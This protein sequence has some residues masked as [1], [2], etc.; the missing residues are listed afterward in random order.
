ML[1][2]TFFDRL[3]SGMISFVIGLVLIVFAII[4]WWASTVPERHEFLVPMEMI[5]I[6]GGAE[7]GAPDETLLIE[8]PEDP[9]DD[10]VEEEITDIVDNVVEL[11][12]QVTTQAEQV[13][14]TET[15]GTPGS[16]DGTGRRGLG[17]GPGEGGIPNEQRWFIRYADDV[18]LSE[19]AKQLDFFGVELGAL[20]PSGEL[21]YLNNLSN[22]APTKRVSSS[23]RDEQRLYMTWQGGSRKAADEKLFERAG[24]NLSGAI[25][26]HFYPKQTEQ[27]LLTQ[28][29][30]YANRK[31]SEIRRTY[32]VAVKEGSG[33]GFVVTRQTYLR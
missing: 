5:E 31:A 24:V 25:M 30:Q 4:V 29:H 15:E 26:F 12:D 16:A 20:L 3:S 23:G 10:P 14:V 9:V 27:L 2:V 19:Y 32:F 13:Q 1:K 6:S 22:S 17:S 7:D 33:Y 8:S 21:V 11:S 18:S 28:E